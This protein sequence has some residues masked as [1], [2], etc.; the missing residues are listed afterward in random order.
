MVRSVL[1]HEH[2]IWRGQPRVGILGFEA[3]EVPRIHRGQSRNLNQRNYEFEQRSWEVHSWERPS[4]SQKLQP[5]FPVE[6]LFSSLSVFATLHLK[7]SQF[8]GPGP[9]YGLDL[10][11]Q[12]IRP[13]FYINK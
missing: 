6:L 12:L 11:N 7:A 13:L 5:L 1:R 4:R 2:R 8:D 9:K 10:L 3:G